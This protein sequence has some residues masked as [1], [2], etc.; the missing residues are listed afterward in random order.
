[1]RTINLE[2]LLALYEIGGGT[3]DQSFLKELNTMSIEC[4]SFKSGAGL[5]LV[6]ISEMK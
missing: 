2:I 6:K 5:K 4:T 3:C 1:M